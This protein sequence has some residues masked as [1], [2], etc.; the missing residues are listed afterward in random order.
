MWWTTEVG[1]SF[2]R[3]E[4]GYENAMKEYNKKQVSY[5]CIRNGSIVYVIFI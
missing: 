5:N 3:L 4:E 2:N 1:I